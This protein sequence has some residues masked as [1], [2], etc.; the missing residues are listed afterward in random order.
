MVMSLPFCDDGRIVD[1]LL[2]ADVDVG[3]KPARSGMD[4]ADDM[5]LA[6]GAGIDVDVAGASGD[7]DVWRIAGV[8]SALEVVVGGEGVA[9][10]MASVAVVRRRFD[11]HG[12][13]LSDSYGNLNCPIEGD[14]FLLLKDDGV[15]GF[16]SGAN[17]GLGAVRDAGLDVDL[18]AALLLLS[19]RGLRRRRCGPCRRGRPARG[20]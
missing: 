11:V 20:R 3:A 16:Q 17:L 4:V 1:D 13:S 9:A 14:G 6:V 8:E 19:G 2:D 10:V 12:I 7:R 5:D 18:A 15:A